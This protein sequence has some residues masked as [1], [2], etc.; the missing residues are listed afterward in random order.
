[1]RF[2]DPDPGWDDLLAR[3]TRGGRHASLAW[4][5]ELRRERPGPVSADGPADSVL[6]ALLLSVD[7]GWT[8][9]VEGDRTVVEKTSG[10]G[11]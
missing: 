1:V 6:A 9:R 11:G 4:P 7:S 10:R 8:M 3:L 2:D 5:D